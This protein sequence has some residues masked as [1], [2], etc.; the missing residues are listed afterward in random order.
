[1]KLQ[2]KLRH[3]LRRDSYRLTVD[4]RSPFPSR[5][6]RL[7]PTRGTFSVAR[8]MR[9]LH[10]C[11][12]DGRHHLSF[13]CVIFG[14]IGSDLV[15]TGRLIGLL[16]KLSYQVGLVHFRTVPGISLRKASVRSVVTFHSCLARRNLFTAVHT[17]HK[18][19]VFTTYN[20]LSAT[21][22]RM[23]GGR[24]RDRAFWCGGRGR[25]GSVLL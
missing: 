2:G 24:G 8:V 5:H 13:R 12:F 18:R 25:A 23:R 7:V 4:L 6:E 22:R 11:S 19:S 9:V 10:Q 1:M 3:F 14:K 16:H 21:R 15:C 17:S 20:V